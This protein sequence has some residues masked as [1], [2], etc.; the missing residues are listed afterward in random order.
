[1]PKSAQPEKHQLPAWTIEHASTAP[2]SRREKLALVLFFF[3]LLMTLSFLIAAITGYVE[4]RGV[5]A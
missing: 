5:F 4:M 3:V 2:M 1:M